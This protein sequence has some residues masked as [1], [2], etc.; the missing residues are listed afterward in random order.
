MGRE[1]GDGVG[2]IPALHIVDAGSEESGIKL[3][4][5]IV[6][7]TLYYIFYH[8]FSYLFCLDSCPLSLLHTSS[9]A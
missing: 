1:R 9:I 8:I 2:S 4:C 5:I 6:C 7:F 3:G